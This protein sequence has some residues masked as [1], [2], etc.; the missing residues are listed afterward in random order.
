ML[1]SQPSEQ[2]RENPEIYG[3]FGGGSENDNAKRLGEEKAF[4]E[5]R[6]REF[7][8]KK[9]STVKS[10]D[11][12]VGDL[13][14]GHGVG[15][16]VGV[17]GEEEEKEVAVSDDV[18]GSESGKMLI[19]QPGMEKISAPAIPL[20]APMPPHLPL[21]PSSA[22]S[23]SSGSSSKGGVSFEASEFIAFAMYRLWHPKLLSYS[24]SSSSLAAHASPVQGRHHESENGGRLP[25]RNAVK[26]KSSS[27]NNIASASTSSYQSIPPATCSIQENTASTPLARTHV[28]SS[29]A[30]PPSPPLSTRMQP[31]PKRLKPSA[32]S[33]ASCI[34]TDNLVIVCPEGTEDWYREYVFQVHALLKK[35]KLGTPFIFLALLYAARLYQ[36]YNCHSTESSSSLLLFQLDVDSIQA[37]GSHSNKD[38]E[39]AQGGPSRLEYK[40]LTTCLLI[41]Q[42]QHGDT[43]YALKTWSTLSSLPLRFLST[44][45][46]EI[47]CMMRYSLHVTPVVYGK[48]VGG[49]QVLGK[50][51]ALVMRAA[52]VDCMGAREVVDVCERLAGGGRTDLVMEIKRVRRLYVGDCSF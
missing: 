39:H 23:S 3:A 47:L 28:L 26:R 15:V 17:G 6:K 52:S 22:R 48:W 7:V 45:E 2:H 41:A 31:S 51:R 19:D 13:E 36:Y 27:A 5:A 8:A 34:D 4:Y 10:F 44:L 40:I 38:N 20:S 18:A 32:S 37:T 11:S 24:S 33:T 35:S 50:E 9:S 25:R 12:A 21:A 30:R 42:K 1:I 46:R 16:D 43:R 14:G 49:M 29:I